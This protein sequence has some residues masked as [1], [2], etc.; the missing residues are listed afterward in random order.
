MECNRTVSR[1]TA[2]LHRN[3]SKDVLDALK[4]A[5]VQDCHIYSARSLVIEEK[6]GVFSL[7]PGRD[8]AEDPLDTLFFLVNP[9][10]EDSLISLII[11]KGELYFPGRGTVIAEEVTLLKSHDLC[12]ENELPSFEFKA[13]SIHL[14]PCIGICCIMKRGEGGTV[15]RIP[16]DMGLCVPSIHFGTG[17]GVR[18]KMGLLRITIPAEKEIVQSF[19]TPYEANNIME[20]MIEAGQLS[21]PGSGFIY[22]FPV[23]K[24]LINLRVK[25]GEQ[26]YAASIEQIITV[27]DS[28]RG[29]TDWR[30][31]KS[32]FE[33]KGRQKKVYIRNLVD[34][35]LLCDAGTGI[36]LVEA[37]MAA[38]AGGATMCHAKHIRSADSPLS[39]IPLARDAC[40][41]V[42]PESTVFAVVAAL[43]EA[44]AFT[45][46]CHG[47]VHIRQTSKAFTYVGRQ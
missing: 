29:N 11:D 20:M 12:V 3:I 13:P 39:D 19:T 31:R 41:M 5:G 1:I 37:S 46:R 10:L 30:N 25:R 27:L 28:I 32:V 9:E 6:K 38:G 2:Y 34:L 45:D 33:K 47:Q 42:V 7:L 44:G 23:K 4:E 16:L 17:T 35:T 40:S 43:R 36:K 26:R 22:G 14:H 21:R 8:L 15:A 24:G 18:D